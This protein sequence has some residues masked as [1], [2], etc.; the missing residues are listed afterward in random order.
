MTQWQIDPA[1][2]KGI[3]DTVGTAGETLSNHEEGDGAAFSETASTELGTNLDQGDYLPQARVAVIQL[4][5]AEGQNLGNIM[6]GISAATVGLRTVVAMYEYA[7]SEMG[8]QMSEAQGAAVEAADSGDFSYFL[9][10]E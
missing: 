8:G 4:L 7:G 10:E 5:E 9:G 6:N 2:A 1:T 3:A